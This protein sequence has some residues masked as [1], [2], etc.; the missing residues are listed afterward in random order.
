MKIRDLKNN[1]EQNLN[2]V[3]ANKYV[4]SISHWI[5]KIFD[6]EK[7]QYNTNDFNEINTLENLA[8]IGIV[9]LTKSP[10]DEVIAELTPEGKELHKDFI[11]HG[12]YL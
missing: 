8:G 11:A 7:G 6:S 12:Y 5:K 10:A 3:R 2:K 1:L 9:S 4:N